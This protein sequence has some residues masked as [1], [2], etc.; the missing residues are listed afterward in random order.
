MI[1][2][3]LER[4]K[5]SGRSDDNLE[6]L[7]KRFDTFNKESLPIVE[8]FEKRGKLRR[9]DALKSIDEVYALVIKEFKG[10]VN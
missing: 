8:Y 3:I 5:T 7:K 6:S 2:R 10:Y 1:E 9:I 4:A